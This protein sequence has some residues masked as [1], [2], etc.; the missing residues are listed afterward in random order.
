MKSILSIVYHPSFHIFTTSLFFQRHI[1]FQFGG[2][3]LSFISFLWPCH[4]YSLSSI[5]ILIPSQHLPYSMLF[6]TK[7]RL[8]QIVAT[9]SICFLASHEGMLI[10]QRGGGIAMHDRCF[11]LSFSF[12]AYNYSAEIDFHNIFK[13]MN[14]ILVT[15]DVS[16]KYTN[17][18]NFKLYWFIKFQK[19]CTLTYSHFFS[20]SWSMPQNDLIFGS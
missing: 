5:A 12:K 7:H 4:S 9:T 11:L 1:I 13:P 15:F 2:V 19:S 8:Q 6:Y 3:L 18:D 20:I 17:P 10:F 14:S 16:L